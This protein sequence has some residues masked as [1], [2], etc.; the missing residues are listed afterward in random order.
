MLQM[1]RGPARDA[2]PGGVFVGVCTAWN[3]FFR[4]HAEMMWTFICRRVIT[5]E[6]AVGPRFLSTNFKLTQIIYLF[7]IRIAKVHNHLFWR[8]YHGTPSTCPG[9]LI[10]GDVLDLVHQ[11]FDPLDYSIWSL[12]LA[13]SR[14]LLSKQFSIRRDFHCGHSALKVSTCPIFWLK[15][16]GFYIFPWGVKLVQ[17]PGLPDGLLCIAPLTILYLLLSRYDNLYVFVSWLRV[18]VAISIDVEF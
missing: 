3:F 16:I 12:P 5:M 15:L 6:W 11:I 7:E 10:F 8:T 9:H 1:E 13:W 14:I 2:P 4:R 18:Y 17:C